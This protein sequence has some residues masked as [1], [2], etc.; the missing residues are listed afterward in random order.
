MSIEIGLL[1]PLS[2]AIALRLIQSFPNIDR[3]FAADN[4]V[5]TVTWPSVNPS[6][7]ESLMLRCAGEPS[8]WWFR[9]YMY[10]FVGRGSDE[11]TADAIAEFLERFFEDRIA[12]GVRFRD[13]KVA[14]GGPIWFDEE[15][16]P[17]SS[18]WTAAD[19]VIRSWRGSKDRD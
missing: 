3:Q 1:E 15:V 19:V 12:C 8:L 7:S 14:S 10:D 4:G 9:G 17:N 6:V 16:W 11:V 5:L 13:G 2:R 18:S